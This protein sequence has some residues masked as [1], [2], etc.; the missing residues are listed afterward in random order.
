MPAAPPHRLGQG[1]TC[2]E[3]VSVAS[4]SEIPPARLV[5]R[6]WRLAVL[7]L[8]VLLVAQAVALVILWKA[9]MPADT[10]SMGAAGRTARFAQLPPKAAGVRKLAWGSCAQQ[11]WPQPYWDTVATMKPDLLVLAGDN[12][13][14]DCSNYSCQELIAAYDELAAKPSFQGARR[15]L[16]MIVTWD[17][18]D[19]GLSDG[20]AA[21]PFKAKAKELF[22]EFWQ[23]PPEDARRGREGVYTH[24]IWGQK[25][26]RLQ[27]ILLDTRWFR[28]EFLPT[29][30][31]M[32][33]GKERYTPDTGN[34]SKSMLGEQQWSWLRSCLLEP[35]ELRLIV[36][37]VQLVADG[38]GWEAWRL[39][40]FERERFYVLLQEV[41]AS[42]VVVLSGDRHVGGFYATRSGARVLEATASS[43]THTSL[44]PG[45]EAGPDRLGPLVRVNNFG[46]VEVDWSARVVNI[47]L[48]RAATSEAALQRGWGEDD[49][50]EVL[51]S[52]TIFL[53]S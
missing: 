49:A 27:V 53:G 14:G 51:Q 12:V 29:D 24:Y 33:P 38:H 23:I 48:R 44:R 25:G 26:Q 40:P 8:L 20:H 41:A 50:G 19:F 17:D 3:D 11:D 4:H 31:P 42:P 7:P 9:R 39:L 47:T 32:A 46:V 6:A 13:Y 37:S 30:S 28:S 2:E 5:S 18:H 34:R 36:S 16:P 43:W 22:V 21:N 35:A 1:E 10:V 52:Q 45:D 15:S